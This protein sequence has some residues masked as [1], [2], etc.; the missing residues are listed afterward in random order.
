MLNRK[1]FW[2]IGLAFMTALS[3]MGFTLGNFIAVH[4]ETSSYQDP[5]GRF[6][7]AILPSYKMTPVAGMFVVESAEGDV[8]YTV[9]VRP[10]ASDRYLEDN[11][12]AQ[13]A[14][15]TLAAGEGFV[16]GVFA[17]N[18]IGV[19]IPW[20]GTQGKTPVSGTAFARQTNNSVLVLSISTTAENTDNIAQILPDLSQSLKPIE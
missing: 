20:R 3:V 2:T 9:S 15:D 1:R 10:K 4:A 19:E 13:V 7:V 8:A 16:P 18:D 17:G 5:A 6:E 14:L 11:E 12:L